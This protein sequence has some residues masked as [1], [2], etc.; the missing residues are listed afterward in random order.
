MLWETSFYSCLMLQ[1]Y[2][3]ILQTLHLLYIIFVFVLMVVY[4]VRSS[5]LSNDP[6][7][8]P[9]SAPASPSHSGA[10]SAHSSGVQTPESLS[11][12]GSPAPAE[13]AAAHAPTTAPA[14]APTPTPGSTAV[15]QSKLA[16]IQEAR[17][18]QSTPGEGTILCDF[19]G[20]V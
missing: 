8:L 2:R 1:L 16:V 7:P 10:L 4:G 17:F 11:R 6:A 5:L 13:P 19:F 9:R 15:V 20:P 3:E 12:E 14:S 18:A